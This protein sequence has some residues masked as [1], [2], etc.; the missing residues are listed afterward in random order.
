MFSWTALDTLLAALLDPALMVVLAAPLLLAPPRSN[1]TGV[2]ALK[3]IGLGL[4]YLGL[5]GLLAAMAD[6]GTLP[7]IVAAAMPA[8]LFG[9]YGL[10]GLLQSDT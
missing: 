5:A 2:G 10:V 6:A 4:G 7:P 1:R 3:A 8:L 9:T